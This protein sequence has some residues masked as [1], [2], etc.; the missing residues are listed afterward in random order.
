[1][2]YVNELISVALKKYLEIGIF[3]NASVSMAVLWV[4]TGKVYMVNIWR[5]Q[6]LLLLDAISVLDGWDLDVDNVNNKC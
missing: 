5:V 1:M 3:L 6:L 2:C 4:W